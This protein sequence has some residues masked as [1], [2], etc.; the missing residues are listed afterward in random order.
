MS[1]CA[2]IALITLVAAAA[3]S[4]LAQSTNTT[5]PTNTMDFAS[6][7]IISRR[8]I[9][10]PNRTARTRYNSTRP[11]ERAADAFS[12][13]GMM[14]YAKGDFA[15]FDGTAP[16]YRK[17]LKPNGDTNNDIA[18]FKVTALNPKSVTLAA[19]TNVTVLSLG[20]Q[21]RRD[22]NGHWTVSTESSDSGSGRRYS[23]RRR[24]FTYN[25]SLNDSGTAADDSQ[26]GDTNS[27]ASD[28]LAN[29]GTDNN[30]N[31]P[32]A[33]AAPAGGG[34]SD[35]LTQLMQRRAQEEQQLGQGQ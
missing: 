20:M 29:A 21:M 14:S 33:S 9:F 32:D 4:G 24:N 27:V 15:F 7:Q 17:A 34:A 5:Q 13:V 25:A 19:G 23:N 10:N 2:F 8:N 16:E 12:F 31:P 18:I 30:N 22:D 26:S 28:D 6:F 35:P 11:E 3:F 1:S